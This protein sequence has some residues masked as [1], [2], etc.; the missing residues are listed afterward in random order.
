MTTEEEALLQQ[1]LDKRLVD[2][3]SAPEKLV[4]VEALTERILSKYAK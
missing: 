3:Q 2:A 1:F 4:S